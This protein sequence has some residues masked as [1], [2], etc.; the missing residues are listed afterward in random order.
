[1]KLLKL[2]LI[3]L[4]ECSKIFGGTNGNGVE[5]PKKESEPEV[6]TPPRT[7][8]S[9]QINIEPPKPENN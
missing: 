4:N 7:E 3:S 1:M 8:S 6:K 9:I 5:P 2:N